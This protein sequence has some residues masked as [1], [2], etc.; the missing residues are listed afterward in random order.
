MIDYKPIRMGGF[1]SRVE[2]QW[3]LVF[4]HFNIEY[5]YESEYFSLENRVN[6]LPDFRLPEVEK[7]LGVP[8]FI[9]VKADTPSPEEYEKC[10]LL[11]IK[12]KGCVTIVHRAPSVR[13]V[14]TSYYNGRK[15]HTIFKSNGHFKEV[16]Y[17]VTPR[18][19]RI[20]QE[21]QEMALVP[22]GGEGQEFIARVKAFGEGLLDS[23]NE[24]TEWQQA[25]THLE[26]QGWHDYLDTRQENPFT[27]NKEDK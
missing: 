12:V 5:L 21:F 11:S 18:V 14:V 27:K 2:F 6:Y 16:D 3:A 24:T 19:L 26:R 8:F 15:F 20:Q 10:R 23:L 22:T 4:E 17:E 25:M 7:E 1:R 9:E 13:R